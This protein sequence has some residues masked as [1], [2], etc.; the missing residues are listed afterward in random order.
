[1]EIETQK[2]NLALDGKILAYKIDLRSFALGY[3]KRV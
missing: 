2:E 1:M 3:A